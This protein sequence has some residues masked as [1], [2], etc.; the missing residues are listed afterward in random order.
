MRSAFSAWSES[1]TLIVSN[2]SV[3][4][5]SDARFPIGS[6]SRK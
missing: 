1:S 6:E 5:T 4:A 3:E 2:D